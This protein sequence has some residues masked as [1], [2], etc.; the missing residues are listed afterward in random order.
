M[1]TG[2]AFHPNAKENM[3]TKIWPNSTRMAGLDFSLEAKMAKAL[4]RKEV[5]PTSEVNTQW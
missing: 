2:V 1:A 4:L 5:H 3:K